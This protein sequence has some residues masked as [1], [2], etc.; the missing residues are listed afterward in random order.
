M[1]FVWNATPQLSK[2]D[3]ENMDTF[4]SGWGQREFG[5]PLAG[6]ISALYKRYFDIP[7]Q[8]QET[9][10][11]DNRLHTMQRTL[12]T[13]AAPLIAEG[14]PLSKSLLGKARDL[15][16]FAS[17]NRAYVSELATAAEQIASR[18]PQERRDFFDSH[19]LA[20]IQIHLHSL[21]MLEAYGSALTAYGKDDKQSAIAS[22][23]QAL[24]ATDEIFETLHRGE[25][26]KWA[27]WYFGERFV[28]LESTRDRLRVLLAKLRGEPLPPPHA[29][30][31]YSE[32]YR[33]QEPFQKDFPLLYPAVRFPAIGE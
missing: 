27:A 20:Q 9:R 23:E 16:N 4:L 17:T 12:D 14:K 10:H 6:D 13:A 25:S 32:L 28:G 18:V 1:R 11:G 8:R 30:S 2:S 31:G 7:Y 21:E 3:G 29:P 15:Q 26:G 5:V 24:R 33:Y 19:L 22:T